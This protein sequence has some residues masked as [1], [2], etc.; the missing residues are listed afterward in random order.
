MSYKPKKKSKAKFRANRQSC[1]SLSASYS[2]TS[3]RRYLIY[4]LGRLDKQT[5]G[6]QDEVN[7]EFYQP[8]EEMAG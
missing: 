6:V 7:Q 5:L 8:H 3:I 2:I 1:L 4:H